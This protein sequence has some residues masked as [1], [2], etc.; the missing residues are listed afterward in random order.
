MPY[1][2]YLRL[3]LLH[4]GEYYVKEEAIA[5][6]RIIKKLGSGGMGEV[7]LAQDN[8]LNRYVAIKVLSEEY[9]ADTE[10]IALFIK[11]AKVVSTLNHPNVCVIHELGQTADGAYYM[12]M[13]YVEGE[14]LEAKMN[15]QA[16]DYVEA[17]DI[18]IQVA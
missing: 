4:G 1:G 17:L 5:H 2:K 3:N 15:G 10:R 14:T 7:Y 11:E 12:V 9:A 18:A 16:L 8:K 13:E 6:Y